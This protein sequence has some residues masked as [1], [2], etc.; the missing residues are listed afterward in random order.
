M[1]APVKEFE[2]APYLETCSWM[3]SVAKAAARPFPPSYDRGESC[4]KLRDQPIDVLSTFIAIG[5]V[6]Q[7]DQ[8]G[9]TPLA[10]LHETDFP[11]AWEL[12]EGKPCYGPWFMRVLGFEVHVSLSACRVSHFVD[13]GGAGPAVPFVIPDP[14]GYFLFCLISTYE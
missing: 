4:P 8:K 5:A 2:F 13:V 1:Q 7:F 9:R 10:W 12:E 14:K 11:M 3:S 6:E